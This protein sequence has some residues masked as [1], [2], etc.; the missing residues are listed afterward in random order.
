MSLQRW[1]GFF[2]GSPSAPV[3]GDHCARGRVRP[4]GLVSSLR[5]CSIRPV[6]AAAAA[7]NLDLHQACAVLFGGRGP[8]VE[9]LRR[10]SWKDTLRKAFRKRAFE[11]HPDRASVL[12]RAESALAAEFRQ[13]E[14]A[15]AIVSAHLS[16]PPPPAAPRTAARP[17]ARPAGRAAPRASHSHGAQAP[18]A[19]RTTHR[20]AA[21]PPPPAQAELFYKGPMPRRSLRFAEFLYY[22]GVVSWQQLIAALTW[23]RRQRP[24][25]GEL[26]IATGLMTRSEVER[27]LARKISTTAATRF[28]E[29]AV[30]LGLLT[31]RQRELL[32]AEQGARQPRIGRYFVEQGL[33]TEEQLGHM[34]HCARR[35][36]AAHAHAA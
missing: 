3:A 34:L 1:C 9:E 6:T 5:T 14:Q 32:L 18:H 24:R 10:T 36:N 8:S 27:V 19:K 25:V 2:E 28:A 7:L 31:P 35:M 20:T 22:S 12:G 15:F 21:P 11:T 17:P 16:A 33:I 13:L 23:Q 26:A 4:W 30:E 29:S